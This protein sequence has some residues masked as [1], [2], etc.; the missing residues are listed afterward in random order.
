MTMEDTVKRISAI[1]FSTAVLLL[2]GCDQLGDHFAQ[3]AT[4][5]EPTVVIAPGFK[6]NVNGKPV[7][8]AGFDAC[9]KSDPVMI[10]LFG[11]ASL[12][13]SH[14]CIVL[15]KNRKEVRVQVAESKGVLTEQWMIIRETGKTGNR[16]YLRTSLKRPDG[17]LVV[18]FQS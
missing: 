2:T 3:M 17:S 16:P 9:P 6:I 10:K 1:L 4:D 11:D 13:G 15:D 5:K 18:P 12:E 14:D 7:P 8:I